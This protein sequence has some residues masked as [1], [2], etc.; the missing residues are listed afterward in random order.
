MKL[1]SVDVSLAGEITAKGKTVRTGIFKEAVEATGT[2]E[3]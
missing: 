3:R 2:T 1:V